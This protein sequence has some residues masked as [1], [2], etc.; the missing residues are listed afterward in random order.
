MK[1]IFFYK[2]IRL[3]EYRRQRN[4][5]LEKGTFENETKREK[6]NDY[7]VELRKMCSEM[8]NLLLKIDYNNF[9]KNMYENILLN[10]RKIK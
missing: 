7:I 5:W 10:G 6:I 2:N 8:E 4:W 9:L 3:K 1:L